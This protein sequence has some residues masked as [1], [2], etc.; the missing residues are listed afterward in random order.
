MVANTCMSS[1]DK[2]KPHTLALCTAKSCE[3]TSNCKWCSTIP[4]TS[5]IEQA[6]RDA[7]PLGVEVRKQ[8]PLVETF[9]TASEKHTII[10][11][12]LYLHFQATL[13]R[14]SII[15]FVLGSFYRKHL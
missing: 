6:I 4:G 11:L 8:V 13:L 15:A 9:F 3:Y 14:D 1:P 2:R 7:T 5:T 10:S 12:S